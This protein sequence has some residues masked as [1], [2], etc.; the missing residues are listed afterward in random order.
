MDTHTHT[1]ARPCNFWCKQGRGTRTDV[2]C[3]LLLL[4]CLVALA[5]NRHRKLK[6]H[7]H[8][9]THTH[10]STHTH[11]HTHTHTSTHTHTHTHTHARTSTKAHVTACSQRC[12]T[13]D[14]RP[15]SLLPHLHETHASRGA[16][17]WVCEH[18]PLV[19]HVVVVLL[20]NLK[21]EST[22]QITKHHK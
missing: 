22:K 8:A 4:R 11:K 13:D 7:T 1:R 19:A 21:V 9:Y 12:E 18:H 5:N 10:T 3:W 15:L 6:T 20:I 16:V 14:R 2:L 17:L